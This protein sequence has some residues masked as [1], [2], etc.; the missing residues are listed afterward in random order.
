MF[1]KEGNLDYVNATQEQL[2]ENIEKQ[3]K[4]LMRAEMPAAEAAMS[5]DRH[6]SA[7]RKY[8]FPERS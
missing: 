8:T 4:E 1:S 2:L 5:P 7:I 6:V 3:V